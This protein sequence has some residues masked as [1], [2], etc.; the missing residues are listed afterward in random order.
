VT[1]RK[2]PVYIIAKGPLRNN[3]LVKSF[4]DQQKFHLEV[5]TQRNISLRV[6]MR[7]TKLMANRNTTVGE[8]DCAV[9]H[10]EAYL[11]FIQSDHEWCFILEDD[12]IPKMENISEILSMLDSLPKQQPIIVSG[13][14]NFSTGFET[15]GLHHL[16]TPP[17]TT[18][19]YLINRAAATVILSTQELQPPSD[20]PLSIIEQGSFYIASPSLVT[21]L[22]SPS[23][24]L[25]RT[26]GRRSLAKMQTLLGIR[27]LR[28]KLAGISC[29]AYWRLEL[30]RQ[31]F[32]GTHLS[33]KRKCITINDS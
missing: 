5:V 32:R 16:T 3:S 23:L 26:A 12:A 21:P 1:S 19:G 6:D 27:L 22:D 25:E 28:W 15:H 31:I 20:W 14:S 30:S 17:D 10:R 7:V 11:T 9:G 4:T 13:Y 18:T 2:F 24:I 29:K 33:C 8:I